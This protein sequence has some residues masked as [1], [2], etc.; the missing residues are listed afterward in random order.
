MIR[1]LVGIKQH[2]VK[3]Y[4]FP[5]WNFQFNIFELPLVMENKNTD[6]REPL[7]LC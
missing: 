1:I 4:V 3:F 2:R 5:P 7:N 6:K